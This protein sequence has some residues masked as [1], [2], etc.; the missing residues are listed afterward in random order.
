MQEYWYPWVPA[1]YR[2]DTLHLSPL[3]DG[4]YRRLID[5]YMETKL[6]LP[7]NEIALSRI[8][9]MPQAEFGQISGTVLAF[10]KKDKG[11]LRHKKCDQVLSDQHERSER[12]RNKSAAGGKAKAE[13]Y[14]NINANSAIGKPEVMPHRATDKTDRT[15]KK[16][17]S[18][19]QNFKDS[20]LS[21]LNDWFLN[22]APSVN[23]LKLKDKILNWCASKGKT[24]KDYFAAARTWATKEHS[25]NIA[26]G[27]TPPKTPVNRNDPYAH[28]TGGSNA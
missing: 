22:N 14:N 8:V 19:L 12:H 9:G 26:K 7:D 11:V 4:V 16:E 28:L 6:P 25:E 18:A 3:E 21:E 20:D 10:F 1:R 13:K 15:D 5:H 24:Y 17:K 27:W 23:K 2:A